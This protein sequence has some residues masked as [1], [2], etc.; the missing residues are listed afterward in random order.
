[1][2]AKWSASIHIPDCGGARLRRLQADA[3]TVVQAV[4]LYR[5]GGRTVHVHLRRQV[6]GDLQAGGGTSPQ[7][8]LLSWWAKTGSPSNLRQAGGWELAPA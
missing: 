5:A 3:L 8:G 7:P 6:A 2:Q 4:A 1:M